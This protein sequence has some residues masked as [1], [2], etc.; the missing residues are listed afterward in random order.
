MSGF[1]DVATVMGIVRKE[2]TSHSSR[3]SAEGRVSCFHPDGFNQE[4]GDS[5]ET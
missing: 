5:D 4:T 2:A 3:D 1:L